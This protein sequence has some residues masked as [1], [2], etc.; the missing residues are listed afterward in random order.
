MRAYLLI[1][2]A[3]GLLTAC[4]GGEAITCQPEHGNGRDG[5][6]GC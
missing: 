2:L 3:A 4:A 5:E 1:L 6:P